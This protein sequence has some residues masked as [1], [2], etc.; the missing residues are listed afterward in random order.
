MP[1]NISENFRPTTWIDDQP[2]AIDANQLN[3]IEEA[4][5]S[6]YYRVFG[7]TGEDKINDTD[8]DA[9]KTLTYALKS[10]NHILDELKISHEGDGTSLSGRSVIDELNENANALETKIDTTKNSIPDIINTLTSE[11]SDAALAAN[12]G[13][14]LKKFI[15]D[16]DAKL[17][18][19]ITTLDGRLNTDYMSIDTYVDT[20][21]ET[22]VKDSAKLGGK[23]ADQYV[24]DSDL[25]S[26]TKSITELESIVNE[27]TGNLPDDSSKFVWKMFD[28]NGTVQTA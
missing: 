22:R 5:Y 27:L 2:P 19:L 17:S 9:K 16:G 15:D 28:D 23:S 11:R 3:R 21:D 18:Q 6:L 4:I 12:Q 20:T 1:R 10:I 7:V 26:I 8:V 25:D 14:A 13:R 24:L